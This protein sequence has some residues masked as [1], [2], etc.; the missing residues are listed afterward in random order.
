MAFFTSDSHNNDDHRIRPFSIA[1]DFTPKSLSSVLCKTGNTHVIC[2]VSYSDTMPS[3]MKN[4]SPTHGWV[5]SEY[6]IIP[7]ATPIR[8]KRERYKVSGR[9]HEIQRLISRCLRSMMNLHVM[10][11]GVFIVDCDIISA[12]GGT[13]TTSL[14]GSI[15]SLITAV[16]RLLNNKTLLVNPL[17]KESIASISVALY[18]DRYIVDPNYEIDSQALTDI[19]FVLSESGRIIEIQGC[20]SEHPLSNKEL[21]KMIE[22]AYNGLSSVFEQI[23]IH[24]K[25]MGV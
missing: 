11:R 14:N 12:D 20:S 3:W 17:K 4:R 25:E 13:R 16:S 22:L 8:Q 24:R 23:K 10:D 21:N 2:G 1:H 5:I 19:S 9:T 6:N 7:S 18:Q 15:F